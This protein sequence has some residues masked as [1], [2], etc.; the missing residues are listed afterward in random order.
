MRIHVVCIGNELLIGKTLNTNLAFLGDALSNA[1]YSVAREV[2]VPDCQNEIADTIRAECSVADVVVTVGGLGPTSDDITRNVVA[3]ALG[4]NLVF[5]QGVMDVIQD[6]LYR[7]NVS[8]ASE[9]VRT[10]SMV[11]EGATV[12]VNRNGTAPGLWCESGGSVVVM[13]PGPPREFNPMVT[14]YL[15]PKLQEFLFLPNC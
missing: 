13:L 15:L 8:V 10:Q 5:H 7:R 6:F 2:C 3:D 9:S 1:G 4:M 14:E 11:P 12:F